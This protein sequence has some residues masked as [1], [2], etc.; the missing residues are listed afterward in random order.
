MLFNPLQRRDRNY[1]NVFCLTASA[2]VEEAAW[3]C[4]IR[5]LRKQPYMQ[6]GDNA[7]WPA[8]DAMEIIVFMFVSRKP[9]DDRSAA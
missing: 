6:Y 1:S 4:I 7:P 3:G 5:L 8:Q 2:E 9:G